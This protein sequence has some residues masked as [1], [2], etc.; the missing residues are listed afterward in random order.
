MRKRS[1]CN[2]CKLYT[3]ILFAISASFEFVCILMQ[4]Q[5]LYHS[6]AYRP[7][8][9]KAF[10]VTS[11]STFF[12]SHM[13]NILDE[14]VSTTEIDRYVISYPA[15][16]GSQTPCNASKKRRERLWATDLWR[17]CA[18]LPD[19]NGNEKMWRCVLF[20]ACE[21]TGKVCARRIGW[22]IGFGIL[23]RKII[24]MRCCMLFVIVLVHSFLKKKKKKKIR[25]LIRDMYPFS[26]PSRSL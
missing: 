16:N 24:I 13:G 10:D 8:R 5:L 11:H 6:L 25:W 2:G 19:W 12:C 3:G 26:I 20:S 18:R 1:I 22:R 17:E 15:L 21:C 4:P 7:F 9:Q 23:F 14:L